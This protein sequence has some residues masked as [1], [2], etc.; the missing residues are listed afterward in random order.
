[1]WLWR[2]RQKTTTP[3]WKAFLHSLVRHICPGLPK[4]HAAS[5]RWCHCLL[6]T[7]AKEKQNSHQGL[8]FQE[9]KKLWSVVNT[10]VSGLVWP[11]LLPDSFSSTCSSICI[12]WTRLP[13]GF[14]KAMLQLPSGLHVYFLHMEKRTWRGSW[15]A[16]VCYPSVGWE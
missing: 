12:L 6:E 1:M 8:L 14:P 3:T 4:G 15:H 13:S 5:Q 10:C 16:V 7:T 9:T 11:L 2:L